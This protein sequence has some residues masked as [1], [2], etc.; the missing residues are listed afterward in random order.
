MNTISL[1]FC[2]EG[3]ENWEIVPTSSHSKYNKIPTKYWKVLFTQRTRLH[4]KRH[5]GEN[6]LPVFENG[7]L[8]IGLCLMPIVIK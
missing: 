4:E 6:R 5:A 3:S 2:G 1:I 8:D 7:K